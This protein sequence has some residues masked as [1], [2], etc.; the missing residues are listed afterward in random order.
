MNPERWERIG[1]LFHAAL[2]QEPGRRPQFLRE[3]CAGDE[4]LRREVEALL[5]R[6]A[7]SP[8]FLESPALEIEARALAGDLAE[9]GAFPENEPPEVAAR[10]AL[11]APR[12]ARPARP[13]WWMYA[14]TALFLCDWT[15]RVYCIA[16]GP[17][18]FDFSS[19]WEGGH[20]V[21]ATVVRGS[22]A[23]QAGFRPGDILLALD[24]QAIRSRSDWRVVNPNLETGRTYRVD[25]DRGGRRLQVAYSMERVGLHDRWVFA[26]WEADGLLLLATALLI[27]FA[28]PNDPLSRLGAL[29]LATLSVSLSFWAHF[30]PGGAV[31]WRALPTIAG[32]LLWIPTLCSYLV[33]PVL[34]TFFGLFPRALIRARWQWGL[35]W[36]PALCFVPAY[37]HDGLLIVYRPT[38]AYENMWSAVFSGFGARL[39][40]LYALLSVAAM[41]A[42]YFRLTDLNDRRRLRVLLVGGAAVVLPA[43]FRL[44]IWRAESLPGIWRWL[45]SGVV[46]VLLAA[47]FVVFP[48]SFAYSILRHRLLDIRLVIRQGARYAVARG[49]LLWAVLA[50]GVILAA[51]LLVH[52]DQPLILILEERGWVYAALGTTALAMHSQRRRWGEAIDRRFFRD[53]YD[54]H[55]LLREVAVESGRARSLADAAPG[56]VA[57]IETALHPEF[58]AIMHR[59]AADPSFQTLASAPSDK[60]PPPIAAHTSLISA[61]RAIGEP[62]DVLLGDS[63]WLRGRLPD[64]EVEYVRRARIDLVVP[65]AMAP[66]QKEALLALGAKRSEEPYTRDDRDMLAVIAS[67]LGLLLERPDAPAPHAKEGLEECPEC[68]VCYDTGAG[69]CAKDGA[70]LATV[71]VPRILAGRYRLERRLGS[72]G[73]GAVYEAADS[74]LARRVALKVIREDRLGSYGAAQRFQREARAAAGFRHPNV[75]TVHDYGIEAGTCAFLVMELLEGATLRDVLRGRQRLEAGEV[76]GVFDGL[77]GAVEAAHRR[78]LI[79]RDLKPEN[80][81]LSCSPGGDGQTVKV[82]DFGI[83]KFLPGSEERAEPASLGETDV[84]ILVGTPGY[85]SPEQLLGEEPAV[86]WDLWALAVTA[87]ET[88]TGVLPFPSASKAEWRRSVLGGYTVRLSQHLAESAGVLGGVLYTLARSGPRDAPGVGG[89]VPAGSGAGAEPAHAAAPGQRDEAVAVGRNATGEPGDIHRLCRKGTGAGCRGATVHVTSVRPARVCR[90]RDGDGGGARCGTAETASRRHMIAS[91]PSRFSVRPDVRQGLP[92]SVTTAPVV[93]PRGSPCRREAGD[94]VLARRT[95]THRRGAF[96]AGSWS[97]ASCPLTAATGST[98]SDSGAGRARSPRPRSSPSGSSRPTAGAGPGT[99]SPRC[100]A[101]PSR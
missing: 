45:S 64:R 22:A 96:A 7:E 21:V 87:Y 97:V 66:A 19:T 10:A 63:G 61:I 67:N 76:V 26:L 40:G 83:A 3:A 36:L 94:G 84:G 95:G 2:E 42:N 101:A 62:L 74:A 86:S 44:L 6:H 73:M 12:P 24:G 81:F 93:S 43:A 16:L 77:C 32:V 98:R 90:T 50:L 72:G 33:G 30:P 65:I 91:R 25:V 28:R 71:H 68:G 47:A 14:L 37:L 99:S 89:G 46:D 55:R 100:P 49:A 39:Y 29:A 82:L 17:R 13:P 8:D 31:L 27:G 18:G 23:D 92:A 38:Q 35:V 20:S 15:L 78:Q 60:A 1:Q 9:E 85:M 88:L 75:V 80:I 59:P 70:A 79:H 34:L 54:A 56:V 4:S 5:A 11:P 52:G 51:D 58:A 48:A 69:Q 41:T 57:R 53:H